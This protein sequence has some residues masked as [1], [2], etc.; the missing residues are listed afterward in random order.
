MESGA[1]VRGDTQL[2]LGEQIRALLERLRNPIQIE[3]CPGEGPYLTRWKLIELPDFHVMLHRFNRSDRDR[4][5]HDHPWSFVSVVL[6]GGYTEV[7]HALKS[8][9]DL[10]L[11]HGGEQFTNATIVAGMPTRG[12]F[13]WPGAVLFRPARWAHRIEIAPGKK[14]WSLVLAFKKERSWGF[15]SREGWVRWR[16]FTADRNCA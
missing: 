7:T 10:I 6:W 4:E 3:G 9:R 16:S 12:R 1:C 5:L 15:F 13:Y 14:A 8:D 11:A 2:S